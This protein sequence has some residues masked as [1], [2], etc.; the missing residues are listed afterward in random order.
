VKAGAA[1]AYYAVVALVAALLLAAVVPF[2][3]FPLQV[4]F[5][6]GGDAILSTTLVKAAA[7][8]GPLHLTRIGAPFGSDAV[9]WSF[10]M[11][12]PLLLTSAVVRATGA[13]GLA[14]NLLWLASTVLAALT[15]AWTFSRLGH[16]RLVAF[17]FALAFSLLPCGFYR[18]VDHPELV[19]PL[20][21]VLGL[22]CLRAAGQAPPAVP[23]LE[24]WTTWAACLAQ[25][26][27]Y[28]PY[29]LFAA[30]LLLVATAIGWA[31]T[32][33]GDLLRLAAPALLLLV[34]GA[35]VPLLPSFVY[36]SH[37]G[38]NPKL[39]FKAAADADRFGLE[40]RPMLVPIDDHPLAPLRWAAARVH[41]AA[42]PEDE[43][44]ST[45]RLGTL[46]AIGL[47]WLLGFLVA[48][49]GGVAA[50]DESLGPP[51][52]LTAAA[53][54]LAQVGGLGSLVSV[55]VRPELRRLDAMA[56]FVGFF[57]LHAAAALVSRALARLPAACPPWVR[58]ALLTLLA[59]AVVGD[60]VPRAY[61]GRL[62]WSTAP[63]FAADADF[64]ERLES[65]LPDRA[66]VFQLP[67]A[68][69]PVDAGARPPEAD[70]PGRAFLHSRRL[71]WSWG[72]VLGR[73]GDWQAE[74]SM[75]APVEM[76]RRLALAGFDGI[77]VDRPAYPR[78]GPR[79]WPALESALSAAVGEPPLV[80]SDGRRSFLRLGA[81]RQRLA[82]GVDPLAYAADEARRLAGSVLLPRWQAGCSDDQG[83]LLLPSRVCGASA[84]AVFDDVGST[85]RR[86][87][88]S[89]G[90]RAGR[91]G[92]LRLR[93]DGHED[94]LVLAG[95]VV[96]YRRELTVAA[97]GRLRLEM[98][99]AG[100]CE[101]T[102]PRPRC[103]EVIDMKATDGGTGL[104]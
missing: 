5:H 11:W 53:L 64:V 35:A 76:A 32:R 43:E 92:R 100:P 66:M 83:T 57:A 2:G 23:P 25:G 81:L 12:L 17:V 22:V 3:P 62:R 70:I 61:L 91:P 52:V 54:L 86:L 55:F 14:V 24:R 8:D 6:Y 74:T 31:R 102:S 82:G 58:P 9:D 99:F 48:R 28:V 30:F 49:A 85:E 101:A 69:I 56:V 37:H 93:L 73:N 16:G 50:P 33:R 44:N 29:S 4:P 60:Q 95:E 7:E 39:E 13:P 89:A 40:L 88:V 34:L 59:T 77:W 63:A 27:C 46:G 79:P 47:A 68:S 42:F 104:P 20:V 71:R 87:V 72:S 19:F 45:A 18:N 98:A 67:H 84:C 1:L 15:A 78:D 38:R 96:P 21:P 94:T 65:L 36:W 26:L 80:S 97:G 10:G 90:L 51:A 41:H 75:L 103:V